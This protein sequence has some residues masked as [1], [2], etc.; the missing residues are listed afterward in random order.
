MAINAELKDLRAQYAVKLSEARK[1]L[2]IES[3]IAEA[4]LT[5]LSQSQK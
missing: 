4:T 3:T 2:E 5:A 1:G